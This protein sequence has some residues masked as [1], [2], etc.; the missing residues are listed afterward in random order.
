[1]GWV[2]WVWGDMGVVKKKGK[3]FNLT[4]YGNELPCCVLCVTHE[5]VMWGILATIK[6][7]HALCSPVPSTCFSV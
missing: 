7:C 3:A 2:K 6:W 4:S 1:M 5:Y